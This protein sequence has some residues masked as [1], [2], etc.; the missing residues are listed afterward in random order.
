MLR[1]SWN[2]LP[3]HLDKKSQ[4]ILR[5]LLPRLK[6]SKYQLGACHLNWEWRSANAIE[7]TF[8][9]CTAHSLRTKIIA[10]ILTKLKI[11]KLKDIMKGNR[12]VLKDKKFPNFFSTVKRQTLKCK[13]NKQGQF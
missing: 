7:S 13:S 12:L 6:K 5:A 9:F 2:H 10:T 4:G 11:E 8:G 1:G 3:I